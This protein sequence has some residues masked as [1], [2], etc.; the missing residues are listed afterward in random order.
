MRPLQGLVD[1]IL[2]IFRAESAHEIDDKAY[3]Q[4]QA[5]PA[6]TDG[7]TSKVKAATAE[8]EKQ[9]K[10]Q[11]QWIHGSKIAHRR[12]DFYGVFTPYRLRV[13]IRDAGLFGY[14]TEDSSAGARFEIAGRLGRRSNI[15][16]QQ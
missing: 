15:T 11:E 7:G 6:A 13:A 4:N 12:H 2:L 16:P 3:Q 1:D 10:Y 14:F 9:N 5:N 8:Q